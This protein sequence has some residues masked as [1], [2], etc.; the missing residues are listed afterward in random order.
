MNI[1]VGN[2]AYDVTEDDLRE[3]FAASGDV[4][5]VSLIK[6]RFSG[7]SKG[8]AFVE[9]PNA[10]QGQDAVRTLNA[11]ALNGRSMKVNEARERES[12]QMR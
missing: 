5:R 10:S 11:R 4:S 7:E 12:R 1:Y 8:F 3:A 9:M 2:L 6:D